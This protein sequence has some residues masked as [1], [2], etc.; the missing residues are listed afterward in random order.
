[1]RIIRKKEHGKKG[2]DKKGREKKG[3]RKRADTVRCRSF[4]YPTKVYSILRERILKQKGTK[5]GNPAK[6]GF[7]TLKIMILRT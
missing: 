7:P 4:K 3:A 6:A 5:N 2:H 1:M